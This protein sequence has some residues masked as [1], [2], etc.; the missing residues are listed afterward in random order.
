MTEQELIGIRLYKAQSKSK[1]AYALKYYCGEDISCPLKERGECLNASFLK[2]CI[3]GSVREVTGWTQRARKYL[4]FV[5]EWEKKAGDNPIKSTNHN[6]IMFIGDYVWLPYSHMNN[7][8]GRDRGIIFHSYTGLFLNGAPFMR[9]RYFTPEMVVKLVE[10]R[11]QAAFGGTITKYANESVPR[12]LADLQARF[13]SIY[14]EV[15]KLKPEIAVTV[16]AGKNAPMKLGWLINSG[17]GGDAIIDEKECYVYSSTKSVEFKLTG[18]S[19]FPESIGEVKVNVKL[20]PET[21]VYISPD[22]Y[23]YMKIMNQARKQEAIIEEVP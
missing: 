5:R 13:P 3:Y 15:L 19:E 16:L 7:I 22:R 2:K 8:D 4:A 6:S 1:K 20:P 17:Y 21:P 9:R 12:L 18:I 14:E 10:F 23:N 11:P